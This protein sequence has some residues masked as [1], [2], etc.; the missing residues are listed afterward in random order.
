MPDIQVVDGGWKISLPEGKDFIVDLS[1]S[2]KFRMQ[3][4]WSM[5][6][7][8]KLKAAGG[9]DAAGALLMGIGTS[10]DPA[11]TAVADKNFIEMR[12]Q[13]SATS[14]SSR[15]LY[16]RH[17]L[18][19]AGQSGEAIRAF[20]DLTG[21][22]ATARGEHVSLQAGAT[23]YVTGLGAGL[24]AQ[25][26]LKNEA[27]HANGTYSV[28][29][30]EIYSE[31]ATTDPAGATSMSFF[32]AVMG[33]NATGIGAVDD[34]AYLLRMEGNAVGAGNMVVASITEA[35]YSHAARCH[36]EGV[37]DVW[38]MFASASG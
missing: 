34:K 10:A 36:L 25:L 12:T 21:A 22:V 6:D 31:G 28:L 14:G 2:G 38:L 1:G 27:L 37:G 15:G 32:R 19:G 33:G 26:Y 4:P 16:W 30:A 23:G 20:T 13:S 29:N 18:S 35:N 17:N 24:D 5:E 8:V 11:T 7:V 3:G 9:S